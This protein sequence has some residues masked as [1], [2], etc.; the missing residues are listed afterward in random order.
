MGRPKDCL[1]M[2][3]SIVQQGAQPVDQ[4]SQISLQLLSMRASFALRRFNAAV[5]HLVQALTLLRQGEFIYRTQEAG[6]YLAQVMGWAQRQNLSVPSELAQWLQKY[7]PLDDAQTALTRPERQAPGAANF[8]LSP[9]ETEII[10]LIAQGCIN[11]EIAARLGITEG[12]VKGH[13]KSI[14]EKLGVRSRSQAISR[15]RELLLI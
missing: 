1:A 15:A 5:E 8:H 7:A 13:R 6:P 3:K 12:T 14:H 4:R 10:G 2:L 9:R 11:K